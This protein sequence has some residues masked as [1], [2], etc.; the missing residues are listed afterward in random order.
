MAPEA[1]QASPAG[2]P[3]QGQA[4]CRPLA[5]NTARPGTV[6]LGHGP[7][8]GAD[9]PGCPGKTA[10]CM[11]HPASRQ[12]EARLVCPGHARKAGCSWALIL[13]GEELQNELE[14][15]PLPPLSRPPSP[16]VDAESDTVRLTQPGRRQGGAVS[17]LPSAP[18]PN[19]GPA[20]Q[21]PSP[22][23]PGHGSQ[24]GKDLSRVCENKGR[25][26]PRAGL[27]QKLPQDGRAHQAPECQ[28]R[29]GLRCH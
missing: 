27:P 24:A 17:R 28:V 2:H 18:N 5:V 8:H 26:G 14:M 4:P 19:P 21:S 9:T 6:S 7:A 1:S 10:I 13:T 23:H 29:P 11:P 22:R 16:Q 12:A 25:R 20:L 15:H 3:H